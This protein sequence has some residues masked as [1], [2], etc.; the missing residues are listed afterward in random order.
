MSKDKF[1]FLAELPS[2]PYRLGRHAI[3][4]SFDPLCD[5]F[6][7]I[8]HFRPI[9]TIMHKELEPVF[10]Q[11]NLGSCTANAALGCLV[12]E[13]FA[14]KDVDYTEE[15][16]VKLYELE[17][18]IDDSQI[19]GSYPP[20]DTG[21]TGPWSMRALEQQ[22]RI[23]SYLHTHRTHT[24]LGMLQDGPIS[25]GVTW[26][27]SM[28]E[29][30]VTN[31]LLVYPES[32]VAGGHQICVVGVDVAQQRIRIRN[33]WGA[34]WGDEGHCWMTWAQFNYLL[35]IGGDVVQPVM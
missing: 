5:A 4:D 11:G 9:K 3:P 13:P 17:T 33:S 27:R 23:H 16:A 18:K 28:F 26:F 7:I 29:L 10:D 15:D 30:D 31:T 24:A 2:N 6:A 19:P 21:S 34:S 20:D 32:G 22:G 8:D 1:V 14:A 35:E 25:I 12:T